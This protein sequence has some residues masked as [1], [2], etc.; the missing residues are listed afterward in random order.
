VA[1]DEG[2]LELFTFHCSW[3][4]AEVRWLLMYFTSSVCEVGRSDV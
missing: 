4:H 2:I 3:R 1:V